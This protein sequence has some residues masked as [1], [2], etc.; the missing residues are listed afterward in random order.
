MESIFQWLNMTP[1]GRPVVPE[2]SQAVA[3]GM[4]LHQ[5]SAACGQPALDR[6]QQ[7]GI[8]GLNRLLGLEH[9][10]P[11]QHGKIADRVAHAVPAPRI[12]YQQQLHCGVFEDIGDGIGPVVGIEGHHDQTQ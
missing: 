7:L 3:L 5:R 2:G 1:L 10:H 4:A 9:H 11:F 8:V 6:T 12:L